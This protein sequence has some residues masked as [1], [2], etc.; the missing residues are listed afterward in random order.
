MREGEREGEREEGRWIC[1]HSWKRERLR[2]VIKSDAIIR[3]GS[4]RK[5]KEVRLTH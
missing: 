5:A 1:K 2:S 3:L 4:Q